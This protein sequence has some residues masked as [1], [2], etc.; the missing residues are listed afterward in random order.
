MAHIVSVL[1]VLSLVVF[2]ST[3]FDSN[4]AAPTG[5][6][7]EKIDE[8]S[9]WDKIGLELYGWSYG[10]GVGQMNGRKPSADGSEGDP[11]EV[12]NQ[13]TMSY[14]TSSGMDLVFVPSFSFR[15]F[16]T[17]DEAGGFELKDPTIGMSGTLWESGGW[18][19]WARFDNAIPLS[20]ASRDDGMVLSPGTL[21]LLSYRFAAS[22]FE[23][24]TVVQ[25]NFSI[26]S[27][28]DM[29]SYLFFSPRLNYLFNTTWALFGYLETAAETE[30]AAGLTNFVSA[31]DT[32]VGVGV[33]YNFADL[34]LEPSINMFPFGDV[35]NS[36]T[37]FVS[38][39]FGGKLK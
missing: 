35:R 2:G 18:S 37:T 32:H 14:P 7:E 29:K 24:Q 10:A 21:A 27:N 4:A 3:S 26:L 28:G 36:T 5:S 22:G 11:I 39:F 23:L 15:P 13:F 16:L 1:S 9:S 31:Q 38:L 25:P 8:R 19:L 6:V 30:R 17:T 12:V 20:T 34:F 33:R